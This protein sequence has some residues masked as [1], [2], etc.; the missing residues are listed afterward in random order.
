MLESTMR[1]ELKRWTSSFDIRWEFWQKS[2]EALKSEDW[3]CDLLFEPLDL[4][5]VGTGHCSKGII[6]ERI[7][8]E[9]P[10]E[11][12]QTCRLAVLNATKQRREQLAEMGRVYD[13][14][15]YDQGRFARGEPFDMEFYVPCNMDDIR[16]EI[17]ILHK[18]G[19]GV[20]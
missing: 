19:F 10:K 12:K 13:V 17:A 1:Q 20:P 6:P 11:P 16:K 18:A 9:V 2:S 3:S 15:E 5:H 7:I 4:I 8:V 14:A